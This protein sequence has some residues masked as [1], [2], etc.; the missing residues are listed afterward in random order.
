MNIGPS[1][2]VAFLSDK[3]AEGFG[4]ACPLDSTE[5]P[6]SRELVDVSNAATLDALGDALS[7]GVSVDDDSVR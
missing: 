5:N 2:A 1:L 6:D 4:V 7:V 3:R